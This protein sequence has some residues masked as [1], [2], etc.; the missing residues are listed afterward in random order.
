[1]MSHREDSLP[2]WR[3]RNSIPMHITA[4]L[5]T[6]RGNR[7]FHPSR[8]S[9][10]VSVILVIHLWD[11]SRSEWEM[12]PDGLSCS[13]SLIRC[14]HFSL[15]GIS[16]FDVFWSSMGHRC[17][18]WSCHGPRPD[19]MQRVSAPIQGTG[20]CLTSILIYNWCRG[21][22]LS[23]KNC[24]LGIIIKNLYRWIYVLFSSLTNKVLRKSEWRPLEQGRKSP[25]LYSVNEFIDWE[26]Y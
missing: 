8:R 7:E 23:E 2:Y 10:H 16:S 21:M 26:D 24:M 6:S 1:M 12:Y 4:P 22:L 11:L 20:G 19:W 13:S 5:W 9:N 25:M 15:R 3:M 17:I 18:H 14:I